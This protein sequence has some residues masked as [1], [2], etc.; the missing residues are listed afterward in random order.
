MRCR[1]LY[2][3]GQLHTGGSERQLYY[4]FRA[5][6]RERYKP[7]VAV[8]TYTDEDVYVPEVRALGVP[9]YSFPDKLSRAGKLMAFRR[10]VR[11]LKPEVIHSYSFY[12]NFA[13]YWAARGTE[14]ISI[15]SIRSD[16]LHAKNDCGPVLGRLSARWPE[17]Q[18]CNSNAA[19]ETVRSYPGFF[20]PSRVS[21]IRNGIDLEE[22]RNLPTPSDE[23]VLIAGVGY[24]LPVKRWE[25]LFT[26]VRELRKKNLD[27]LVQIAGDGPLRLVLEQQAEEMG[28]ADRVQFMG[29][30][31]DV[32]EFLAKA[33]FVVHT[34]DSEGSPNAVMEAM[35][36]GR[37]VVATDVGD[38]RS[39]IEDG[40]TG[41][42][43]PRDDGSVL[44]ERM[45]ELIVNRD[46]CQSMGK[47]G[48][49]KIEREYGLDRL[50]EE[51]L[52]VYRAAGWRNA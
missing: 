43:V 50:V 35:A 1:L 8:W 44:A 38:I 46:L 19:A 40:K 6:D 17:I 47:A 32:P 9:L 27:C 48:R 11:Q 13:A 36:C 45:K 16:F 25:R 37:A 2:L 18:T 42:V 4:L 39:L 28:V 7:A 22:F 31:D 14:A 15:G 41:F 30:I 51:T 24:L 21:V 12:T 34:A 10:L 29:H 20:V 23:P 26:A 49:E 52:S 3:I 33:T 5:M